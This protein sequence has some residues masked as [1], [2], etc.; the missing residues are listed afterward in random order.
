MAPLAIIR[1]F[2]IQK[3]IKWWCSFNLKFVDIADIIE[4]VHT[5]GIKVFVKAKCCDNL[6]YARLTF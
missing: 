6:Y 5:R 1:K 4:T 2:L 3:F